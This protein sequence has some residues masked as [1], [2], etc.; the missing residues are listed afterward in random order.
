MSQKRKGSAPSGA[1]AK[2]R[3]PDGEKTSV[4]FAERTIVDDP[5]GDKFC[6]WAQMQRCVPEGRSVKDLER[7]KPA[8]EGR[9]EEWEDFLMGIRVAIDHSGGLVPIYFRYGVCPSRRRSALLCP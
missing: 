3:A 8:E 6:S 1:P 4:R 5:Q 9:D 7:V 2:K